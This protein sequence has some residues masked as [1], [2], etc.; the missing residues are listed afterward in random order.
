MIR[1]P[2][3]RA[4][5]RSP[6]IHAPTLQPRPM[7]PATTIAEAFEQARSMDAPLSERLS[8]YAQASRHL[9]AAMA[10]AIDR[11]VGRLRMGAVAVGAPQVGDRMPPFLLPDHTGRLVSLNDLIAAGPI[12]VSFA[13]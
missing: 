5:R 6:G 9:N 11:L 13:R 3:A 10:D 7:M 2:I 4:S 1:A 8:A 12:A